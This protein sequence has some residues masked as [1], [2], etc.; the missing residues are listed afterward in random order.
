MSPK[1]RRWV[2]TGC[3]EKSGSFLLNMVEHVCTFCF[4]FWRVVVCCWTYPCSL[5]IENACQNV[6]TITGFSSSVQLACHSNLFSFVLTHQVENFCGIMD[7]TSWCPVRKSLAR[8]EMEKVLETL[9]GV[10]LLRSQANG[11][12][13]GR[14]G[15]ASSKQQALEEKG[16]E[17]IWFCLWN[18][19]CFPRIL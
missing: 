8:Y 7:C 10:S 17:A 18:P 5:S 16:P 14:R 6:R 12:A 19:K 9:W 13:A 4:H 3:F 2:V 11:K 15:T 1:F